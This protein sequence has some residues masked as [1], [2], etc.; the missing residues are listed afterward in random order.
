MIID[1]SYFFGDIL[2]G[3]LSEQSVQ[4]KVNWF[5]NQYEPEIL[6]GL[7]GYE[8][9]SKLMLALSQGSVEAKWMDLLTGAEY[10]Y[11]G[12]LRKW[13]GLLQLPAGS[14]TINFSNEVNIV[15]G[16]GG[17]YDPA[18]GTTAIIP[19]GFV[20]KD[21]V[22]MQRAYGPMIRRDESNPKATDNFSVNG[23]VLTLL[24]GFVFNMN[25][26]YFYYGENSLT[27]SNTGSATTKISLIAYYVYYWFQRSQSTTTSGT[28]EGKTQTQNAIP[29]S[30]TDKMASA[31]NKMVSL[32][33]DLYCFLNAKKD[34]YT[35]WYDWAV[36]DDSNVQFFHPIN[37][38]NI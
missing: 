27:V 17:T 4:D 28:G 22:F 23:N 29:V 32:N 20:G 8:T 7:L 36:S 30:V 33:K 26:T 12:V 9:Y 31:W 38:F 34:V 6:R 24:N 13:N 21:F 1:T 14:T 37:T 2:I 5:I 11:Q 18:P 3:Q 16:R 35:E 15:V 19:S 10:T 25:D